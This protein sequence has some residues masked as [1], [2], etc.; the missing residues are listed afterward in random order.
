MTDSKFLQQC[1]AAQCAG[2][3]AARSEAAWA[4]AG[5]Q[6][7]QTVCVVMDLGCEGEVRILVRG[8]GRGEVVEEAVW[9][10]LKRTGVMAAS[11]GSMAKALD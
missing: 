8:G 3:E 10:E 2:A 11:M 5:A 7:A 4:G 6:A 1:A 9:A